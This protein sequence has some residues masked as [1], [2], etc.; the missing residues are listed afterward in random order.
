MRSFITAE[1]L[2]GS[3]VNCK[4]TL[5]FFL[6][7]VLFVVTFL[8]S[9]DSLYQNTRPTNRP[10]NSNLGTGSFNGPSVLME[11]VSG[12]HEHNNKQNNDKEE[13][14]GWLSCYQ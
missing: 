1:S 5:A 8:L 13:N 6:I 14:I 7:V 9:S 11:G 12:Q 10:T 2:T 4:P 3:S